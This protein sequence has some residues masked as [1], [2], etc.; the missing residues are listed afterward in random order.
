MYSD[1]KQC[2]LHFCCNCSVPIET[3]LYNTMEDITIYL[4]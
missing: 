3:H 1:P 2:V 4:T